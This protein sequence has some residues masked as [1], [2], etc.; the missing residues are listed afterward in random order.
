MDPGERRGERGS[1][2]RVM[3][4]CGGPIVTHTH[5]HTQCQGK[6]SVFECLMAADS[7][8]KLRAL[9]INKL[10]YVWDR[11]SEK[12]GKRVIEDV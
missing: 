9:A 5:T 8:G 11:G 1:C 10:L 3:V 4:A 6:Q 12:E 7:G 2:V